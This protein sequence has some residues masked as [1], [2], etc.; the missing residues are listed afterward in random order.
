MVLL[1]VIRRLAGGKAVL[2]VVPLVRVTFSTSE[3]KLSHVYE[4]YYYRHTK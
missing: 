2:A 3:H 1:I 4:L